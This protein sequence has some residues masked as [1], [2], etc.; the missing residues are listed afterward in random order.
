[1]IRPGLLVALTVGLIAS[2]PAQAPQ[3]GPQINIS[4]SG[5][6]SGGGQG[7]ASVSGSIRCPAPWQ[8]SIHT[9][10]V[11]FKKD[12]GT[13]TV[14]AFL[15]VKGDK[16]ELDIDLKAGSYKCWAVIDVKD[17]NGREKQISS[18]SQSVKIP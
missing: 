12:G 7:Q 8:L 17:A 11:R 6:G 18:D 4:A 14:N 15:P 3:S 2:A 10:T 16:F 13:K 1:M 5:S 9:V